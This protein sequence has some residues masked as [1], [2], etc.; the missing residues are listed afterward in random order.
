[1]RPFRVVTHKNWLAAI[2][3][4]FGAVQD[5][6]FDIDPGTA[7]STYWWAP[8]AWVARASKA[9]VDLPVLS[10]GPYWLDRLPMPYVGRVVRTVPLSALTNDSAGPVFLKLPE[11][12]IDSCPARVY[13]TPRL[14]DTWRQFGFPETTLVQQ[15]SV[16]DFTTEARFFIADGALTTGRPYRHR[17]WTWGTGT[18]PDLSVEMR[19]L[20]QLATAVLGDP[21]IARP[22][23]F[24]L[25]VGLTS[26][27]KALVIEANAAWSSNPYDA[28]PAG[29]VAAIKASHDFHNLHSNWLWS[30]RTNPT[31]T[32]AAPL[33]V[34]AG[35]SITTALR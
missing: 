28:D 14:A 15:Q 23:G 2:F 30:H 18:T 20:E 22:P 3:Q 13:D 8:G 10:C 34:V 26:G 9:G 11:A 32:T 17:D 16:V 4:P 24:V 27:G 12:K 31:W 6:G 7:L 21:E 19:I 33:K 5:F 35:P 25:D 1:M 29:V